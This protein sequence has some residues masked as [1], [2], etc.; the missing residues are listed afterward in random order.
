MSPAPDLVA[1]DPA[2][3]D[4]VGRAA[5]RTRLRHVGQLVTGNVANAALML[6]ASVIAARALG[7]AGFG[8][9]TLVLALGRTV[10]RVVRFES[11][12]PLIRFATALE[13]EERDDAAARE[14]L[15]RLFAFGLALDIAAAFAA[16]LLA[17]AVAGAIG[18]AVGLPADGV[19]LVAIYAVAL[20]LNWSGMPTAVLRLSGRFGWMA[21]Y[22]FAATLLRIALAAACWWLDAGVWAFVA[23]WTASQAANALFLSAL[24][25]VC[26]RRRGIAPPWRVPL[27]TLRGPP[28]FIRFAISTNL[29]TTL[30]TLTVEA[31]V[32]LVGWL[33]GPNA[34]GFL[35]IAKRLAKVGQQVGAQVQAVL[36]PD[37]AR[38][39]ARGRGHDMRR[40][41][42][43][44]QRALVG[45][46]L[47]L[48]A[49]AAAFGHP[50][51]GL[52]F[53][54]PF[55]AAYPLLV[56]QMG[57]VV[58]VLHAAPA[59]SALLAM[60]RPNAVLAIVAAGTALFFAVAFALVPAHGAIGVSVA[61]VALGLFVSLAMERAV[62]GGASPG[63][64]SRGD[65]SL[66]QVADA[67]P[68]GPAA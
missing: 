53:G 28:G 13:G 34:A 66:V 35:H 61:H 57:A 12:Q 6:L 39:W 8:V 24:A 64:A 10:E 29:S 21:T 25:L 30:R 27:R 49:A 58:F 52:A 23:A 20:A 37:V 11:W 18:T 40:T 47:V 22:Q 62:R 63:G 31:D 65:G 15:A 48:L 60:N 55:Q 1:P 50:A 7:P 17:V 26:L 41:V 14:K 3:P 43:Q 56:V 38:M 5:N 51:L 45:T 9:L 42:G 67:R 46:A 4:L 33:V 19:Q 59:R 2:T 68:G 32:L 44:V 36:Y 16:A 54:A